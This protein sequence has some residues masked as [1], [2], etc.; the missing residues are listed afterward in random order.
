MR[1]FVYNETKRHSGCGLYGFDAGATQAPVF[2]RL[3]FFP[4]FLYDGG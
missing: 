1:P 2:F 4:A 3:A